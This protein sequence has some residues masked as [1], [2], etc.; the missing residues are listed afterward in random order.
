M[1][2]SRNYPRAPPNQQSDQSTTQDCSVTAANLAP[3]VTTVFLSGQRA[4]AIEFRLPI[5]D[6]ADPDGARYIGDPRFATGSAISRSPAPLSIRRWRRTGSRISGEIEPAPAAQ[7][8]TAAPTRRRSRRRAAIHRCSPGRSPCRSIFRRSLSSL[9]SC[10]R[11]R[12]SCCCFP[13]CRTAMPE[14]WLGGH[15]L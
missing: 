10:P 4:K 13:S 6:C 11:S 2:C 9:H 14:G 5:V 12:A 1:A 7:T 8:P 15:L 3:T